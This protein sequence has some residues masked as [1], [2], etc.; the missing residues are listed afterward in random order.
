[1][2]E[3][4]RIH[5]VL[6]E[7]TVEDA[8]VIVHALERAGFDPVWRH[9]DN[10]ESFAAALHQ[11]PD[12]VLCDF[13]LRA[14]DAPRAIEILHEQ[15]DPVPLIIVPELIGDEIRGRR[16]PRAAGDDVPEARVAHLGQ[17]VEHALEFRRAAEG[18]V[19]GDR[20]LRASEARY[21]ALVEQTP[22]IVYTWGVAGGLGT[23]VGLYV[24]PHVEDVLGYDPQEWLENP[25]LWM[26][27]L[28][29]EDRD[30]VLT[31]VSR[32][33]E[34][35]EPFRSE[36]RM[37]AKDGHLVW[38]HDEARIVNRDEEGASTLYQGVLIDIT[39][40]KDAE[41]E[42]HRSLE[43]I[44]Y[45]DRQ[46]RELLARIVTIQEEER[47][48]IA[49]DI[50][51]DS[52]QGLAAV[53][54]RLETLERSN[55]ALTDDENFV[56]ARRILGDSVTRLRHL[57]FEL[58]PSI[59]DA[60]G[61]ALTIRAHLDDLADLP[62]SPAYEL[63]DQMAREPSQKARAIL[64]RIAQEGIANARKHSQAAHVDVTLE[65][66]SGGF[67]VGI[68]DDGVGFD[69]DDT[70]MSPPHHLGLTS[71]RERA[72]L[73]GGWLRIDSRL[74]RGTK[75]EIWVPDELAN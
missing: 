43:Q 61:L 15:G 42:R 60:S 3:D 33:I 37:I 35:G 52:L 6:V 73:A 62:G 34:G 29:P 75:V 1:M 39:A 49:A 47:Q 68:T 27:R 50:H 45:L 22:A 13:S 53:V 41:D 14:F 51:D 7:D 40:R 19:R 10:E 59:L 28:H 4:H 24:S 70:T 38:L 66:S 30:E 2:I 36:Y 57:M 20:A 54:L 8:A 32:C 16:G 25:S 55:L 63:R 21:R 46:R 17:A 56:K 31:E 71:M 74:D 72:E 48:R 12:V 23:F 44:R 11:K 26:E 5:V 58:H 67:Y 65:E 18:H 69:V 9:V 64:Y